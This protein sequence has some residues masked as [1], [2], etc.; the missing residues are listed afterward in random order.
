M[1][2][3]D[4]VCEA[5]CGCGCLVVIGMAMLLVVAVFAKIIWKVLTW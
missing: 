3:E 1:S 5:G 4:D 2:R